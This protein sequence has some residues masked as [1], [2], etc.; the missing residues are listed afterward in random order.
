MI[1]DF[2]PTG[3]QRGSATGPRAHSWWVG[4]GRAEI[5]TCLSGHVCTGSVVAHTRRHACSCTGPRRRESR[6]NLGRGRAMTQPGRS[7]RSAGDGSLLCAVSGLRP[8]T[9]AS[10]P[11]PATPASGPL[12]TTRSVPGIAQRF[13]G[14]TVARLRAAAWLPGT[15]FFGGFGSHLPLPPGP[16]G[17]QEGQARDLWLLPTASSA[18]RGRGAPV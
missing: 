15:P 5:H 4:L 2:K 9:P 13:P 11:P 18:P 12:G 16:R 7:C 17:A 1:P 8:P 6:R 3:A 10:S 14:G